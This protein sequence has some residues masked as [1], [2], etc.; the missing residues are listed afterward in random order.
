MSVNF[1]TSLWSFFG[2]NDDFIN[3]FW[4]LLTFRNPKSSRRGYQNLNAYAVEFQSEKQMAFLVSRAHWFWWHLLLPTGILE[5]FWY[6]R[7]SRVLT[8]Q[9]W[10]I[11]TGPKSI[12]FFQWWSARYECRAFFSYQFTATNLLP[13][14]IVCIPLT[15]CFM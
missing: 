5:E 10:S 8:S 2:R 1:K 13:W 12:I 4:D 11:C 9:L 7:I 3:V 6:H 14:A 15:L